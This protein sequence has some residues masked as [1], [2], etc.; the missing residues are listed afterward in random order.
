MI[1]WLGLLGC[2][3]CD[4]PGTACVIAGD[5]EHGF[6]EDG[7][8]ARKTRLYY[9]LDVTWRPGTEELYVVD[10]NN[11][12][13]RRIG[14]KGQIDTVIGSDQPGD[15]DPGMGDRRDPG[16]PG[17]AVA[18][19]HPVQV[20]FAPDGRLYLAAW[21]NHKV[22]RWDPASGLVRVV[23]A[24]H[25]QTT[26]NNGGFSGDGGPAEDAH[27]RFPSSVGFDAEGNL[28]LVDQQNL[29]IRRMD[30][31]GTIDTFAG[32][33]DLGDGD[34]AALSASFAFTD[35]P[36]SFQPDPGGA[37]EIDRDAGVAWLA[38]SHNAALRRIELAT[39]MVSTLP[40]DGL[41]QPADIELGPDGRLYVADAG[42]HTVIAVDPETGDA[43][44]IAGTGEPGFGPEG[45]PASEIALNGPH[46]VDL[47]DAGTLWI[48][49]TLNSRI[50]K[51]AP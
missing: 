45:A 39:G 23:I 49:D 37:I 22:R 3:N 1:L 14:P 43:E 9:P 29:R 13:V 34:G 17:P 33:G 36:T 26:G 18:L 25:D 28:F 32:T 40:V 6:A 30:T 44:R 12:R 20:E 2:G 16:A 19:N 15:G 10:W 31:A 42:A 11:E 35:D 50:W 4:A 5:G 41:V 51:V 48:A 47:D 8:P 24:N 27:V 21:H 38:D 7:V 46:G